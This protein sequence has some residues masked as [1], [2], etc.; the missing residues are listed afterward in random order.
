MI[1]F[2]G[3]TGKRLRIL[4]DDMGWNQTQLAAATGG[5]VSQST[6]SKV[7]RDAIDA[8]GSAIAALAQ[9]LNTTADFLLMLTDDP[10]IPEELMEE[11]KAK[12]DVDEL[13]SIYDQLTFGQREHLLHIARTFQNAD[14][15]RIIE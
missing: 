14:N 4:R 13:L 9:A 1:D 5:V 3:T 2:I 11:G 15:P 7:E 6:V 10:T 12:G 8:G